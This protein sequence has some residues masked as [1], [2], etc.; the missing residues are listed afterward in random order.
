VANDVRAE[1][2]YLDAI[3]GVRAELDLPLQAGGEMLGVLNIE[4]TRLNTFDAGDVT[5]LQIVADQVATAIR[6]ARLY[7]EAQREKRYLESL[8]H[9]SPVAIVTSD[10]RGVIMSWNPAAEQLF[11]YCQ[12]EAVGRDLDDLIAR[13]DDVRTEALIW[14]QQTAGG[15]PVHSI[16]RRYRKDGSMVDV[17]VTG[18]PVMVGS[19]RVGAFVLY[20][21]ITELEQARQQALEARRVA[22]GHALQAETA[23]RA[24]SAFLAMMSHEIRTPLNAI[25]GMSSL[26]LDTRLTPEQHEFARTIRTSGNALLTVINDIL[27]FSKIEAGK[28]DLESEPFD[29]PACLDAALELVAADAKEKG[30]ELLCES[31]PRTPR[32]LIGDVNRLRQVLVNL[33]SNAVKFTERGLVAVRVEPVPEEAGSQSASA[34]QDRSIVLHFSVRD[35]GIGIP[36]DRLHHLFQSFSQI[37]VSVARRYGG[38]GLGLAISRRLVDLM[39]GRIW[40]ESSEGVGSTFH[41]TIRVGVPSGAHEGMPARAADSH[42]ALAAVAGGWEAGAVAAE[43]APEFD[44][45]MGVRQ[46]LRILIAEDHPTNQ[47]LAQLL[48]ERLGYRADAAAN[49]Q[50]ALRALRRQPYDVVL[51]D[52]QMPEMDGLEATR[53]ICREWPPGQRPR[54]VALTATAAREDREA[55]LEAG[56]DD[57]LSKPIRPAELIAALQRAIAAAPPADAGEA[58]PDAE[59]ARDTGEVLDP[60]AVRNLQ[61]MLGAGFAA[62]LPQLIDT[63]LGNSPGLL[64]KLQRALEQGDGEGVRRAAHALKSSSATFGATEFAALCKEAESKGR[65]GDMEAAAGFVAQIMA[66]YGKVETALIALRRRVRDTDGSDS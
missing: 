14:T 58:P 34:A 1:P 31:D 54:I 11:G 50:E 13:T 29:L 28:M 30:L 53:A 62:T 7:H 6:N 40:V 17:T 2:D 45:R 10:L 51:M 46:P 22:E 24:K 20:H 41:F 36:Q 65:A 8:I 16:T 26:L 12:A 37:D 21:D 42:G 9:N 48:L 27:D 63:F 23:N 38:T 35:T 19:E 59:A 33:L 52:V 49:G 32:R 15:T 61:G 57:Y 39:G 18:V 56:M 3:P 4:S 43:D 5:A 55:C 47:R 66:A 64:D 44:A 25:I 60:E